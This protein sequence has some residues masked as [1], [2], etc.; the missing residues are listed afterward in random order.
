MSASFYYSQSKVVVDKPLSTWAGS[1]FQRSMMACFGELP[2]MVD[3]DDIAKLSGMSAV[4][5][6]SGLRGHECPYQELIDAIEKY[7]TITV[8]AEY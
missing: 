4:A 8:R 2:C 1:T 3:R 6:S 7:G 5:K